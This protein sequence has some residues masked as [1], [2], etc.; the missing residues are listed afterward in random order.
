VADPEHPE[1]EAA[2]PAAP[3]PGRRMLALAAEATVVLACVIA[4]A[5]WLW[6]GHLLQ[7]LTPWVVLL[8]A[9]LLLLL[10]R[11]PWRAAICLLG[12]VA[13]SW[14]GLRVA[15]APAAPVLAEA[16]PV[17][18]RVA[19]AD[20]RGWAG[21][22][23][24]A[25]MAAL[26]ATGADVIGILTPADGPLPSAALGLRGYTLERA[27]PLQ[28]MALAPETEPEF[29][30]RLLLL[31][32]RRPL[33]QQLHYAPDSD[34]LILSARWV[35]EDGQEIL[36]LV[37]A[38]GAGDHPRRFLRQL[39]LIERVGELAQAYQGPV[40]L[41]AP[42]AW[43]RVAPRWHRLADASGVRLPAAGLPAVAPAWLPRP[44]ASAD[45]V[46][47]ARDLAFGSVERV[48][49]PETSRDGVVVDLGRPVGEPSVSRAD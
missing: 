9:I 32:R 26:G 3:T 18:L 1:D 49:L 37:S 17:G 23:A 16:A 21:D 28:R 30:G 42:R 35:A 46:I 10:R 14:P 31:T 7:P 43:D 4:L 24:D 36:V 2:V 44:F 33:A 27:A 48:A 20:L 29:A 22:D 25:V 47:A 5:E 38:F 15:M 13:V 11:Q 45:T 6:L 41:C 39:P 12:L 34:G 8:L 19:A 40:V